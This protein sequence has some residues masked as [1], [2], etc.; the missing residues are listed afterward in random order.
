MVENQEDVYYYITLMNEQ[1][2]PS[3]GLNRGASEESSRACTCWSTAILP[4]RESIPRVQ[5]MGSGA[6][7]REVIAAADL[8]KKDWGVTA[9]VWSCPVIHLAGARRPGHRS[10][11]IC[12]I[13]RRRQQIAHVTQALGSGAAVRS[14]V[15]D[16]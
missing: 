14:I 9:D 10:A 13:P 11:G 2:Y 12:C 7:L 1:N 6:I 15:I 3:P 8:L 16:R 5:L 4:G